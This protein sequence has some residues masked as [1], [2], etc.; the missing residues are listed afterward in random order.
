MKKANLFKVFILVVSIVFFATS[1]T[2][3]QVSGLEVSPQAT[4]GDII[5]DFDINVHVRKFFGGSAGT[6]L[7]NFTSDVTDPLVVDAIQAEIFRMGGSRAINVRM[8]HRASFL[9]IFLNAITFSIYSPSYVRV[10]GTVIR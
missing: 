10:T 3:F 4:A 7:L 1:C 5:G 9:D 2:S 8:E 6:N